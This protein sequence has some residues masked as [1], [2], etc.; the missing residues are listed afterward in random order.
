MSENKEQ[1]RKRGKKEKKRRSKVAL[2]VIVA[3]VVVMVGAYTV[4]ANTY[5][6]RFFPHTVINGI[7]ASEKTV[8]E[9]R[10]VMSKQ[11]DNF[12]STIKS[13]GNNDEIIKGAMSDLHLSRI[14]HWRIC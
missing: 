8:D 11:I 13:R 14:I 4:K 7:D 10:Q 3:G 6:T 5:R 9:V 1:P 12:E 2:G